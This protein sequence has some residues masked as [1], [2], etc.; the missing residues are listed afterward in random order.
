MEDAAQWVPLVP[1]L[2]HGGVQ[3][4]LQAALPSLLPIPKA[5][6]P[7]HPPVATYSSDTSIQN[8]DATQDAHDE[9]LIPTIDIPITHP[10][11]QDSSEQAY[12]SGAGVESSLS[13]NEAEMKGRK[14][15]AAAGGALFGLFTFS[16]FYQDFLFDK[17]TLGDERADETEWVAS[18][19][20]WLD[21]KACSWFGICGL[22]HLNQAHWT[23]AASDTQ[24]QTVIIEESDKTNL[25]DF[26]KDARN[27][28]ADYKP[29]P[30]LEIPQYVID[31]APLIHLFSGEE[32]WPGDMADHLVH[33][34]PHLNYT[35]I[36][37][38]SDH[39][40]ISNLGQLN[41]WGR[42]VYLQSDDNVE[43]RPAW[44]GA[45]YNIP[46]VPGNGDDDG[47]DPKHDGG[48]KGHLTEDR[49][50]K[51]SRWWHVGKGDTKG[52]GGIRPDPSTPGGPIPTSTPEGDE[53][54]D[55]TDDDDRYWRSE[56][57]RVRRKYKGKRVVGGR[58]DA[59]VPLVVVDKGD[60]V[61]DAFWFFFYSYNLG[62]AVFNVRFGNH[63]GD[64]EHTV[65]RFHH[66]EPKAV[67]FSEHSFGEAYAWDAVEKSG[68]RPIGFS[69]TGT[70]AMYATE[71]THPYVLPGGILHDVT[72]RGPL[73]DPVLNMYSYK[74]N[75][76]TDRLVS[77]N[78]NPVAPTSWFYFAGH[79]GDKFYP[80]SDPRQ[81]RFLGQY[82]YVNGPLGPRFKNL[83][84]QEICQGN[85]E[86]TLKRR[87]GE[88]SHI[89]KSWSD[90][91]EGEE[92]S[93]EDGKRVFGAEYDSAS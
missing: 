50:S 74:Y 88:R 61:V 79:W 5:D 18:S 44:L 80:L 87:A 89:V 81:Y 46:N 69:A 14:P 38:Q 62:N 11:Q 24:G 39:P 78:L 7:E 17:L 30:E 91:G 83:G 8:P 36:Q 10:L 53:L 55:D 67:F 76:R 25:N 31:H 77:S 70:H 9:A 59:P 68:K 90:L 35:P 93:E 33:T 29:D 37:A 58:S 2:H 34:T 47:D 56:L 48:A 21:R 54:I 71:G 52:R 32:Y 86:C 20:S 15:V 22:A 13:E 42:F 49:E 26:W 40:T 51:K 57:R 28:P 82:H 60:G 75:Y 92:M 41:K 12:T 73:W 63:V 27:I 43:D 16:H 64:W 84:R 4:P 45:D 65:V 19:K 3:V 85:G 66:G 6:I 1:Y 23:T 72:D